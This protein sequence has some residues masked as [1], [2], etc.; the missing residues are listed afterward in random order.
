MHKNVYISKSRQDELKRI[1]DMKST[2][3]FD[4]EKWKIVFFHHSPTLNSLKILF[5]EE[6]IN[7]KHNQIDVIHLQM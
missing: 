3:K 6:I 7:S 5:S 1:S 2:I 4:L